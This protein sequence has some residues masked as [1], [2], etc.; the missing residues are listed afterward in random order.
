MAQ[1]MKLSRFFQKRTPGLF[2]LVKGMRLL[3][4]NHS[5]LV[6][7]GLMESY[8]RGYPCKADGTAVPWMNYSLITLLEER[9]TEDV[10]LLEF[11][12]G[13]STLFFSRLVGSVTSIESAGEWFETTRQMVGDSANLFLVESTETESYRKILEKLDDHFDVIL[14]DGRNRV[15][16]ALLTSDMVTERGVIL[17]DDSMRE[18]YKEGIDHLVDKGFKQLDFEGVKPT[19]IK[20]Y[21]TSV[22]YKPGNCLGL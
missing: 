13:Y 5:Y 16:C 22:F 11:G 12:S 3:Y 6:T 10:K 18:E 14:I 20:L 21:R 15:S 17:F 19:S 8:R 4:I 9:L 2:A 7:S 1:A